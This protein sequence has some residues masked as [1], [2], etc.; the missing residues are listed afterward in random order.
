MCVSATGRGSCTNGG[1]L[2]DVGLRGPAHYSNSLTSKLARHPRRQDA[3]QEQFAGLD[4]ATY[5]AMV[6]PLPARRLSVQVVEFD[7]LGW[8]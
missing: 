8:P 6:S 3:F 1:L 7:E 5:E 2:L 4:R